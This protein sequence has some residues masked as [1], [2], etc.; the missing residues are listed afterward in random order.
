MKAS[1]EALIFGAHL[2]PDHAAEA[3]AK[4]PGAQS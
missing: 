2:A 3:V 4:L 1:R